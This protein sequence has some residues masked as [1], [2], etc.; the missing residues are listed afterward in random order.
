[1]PRLLRFQPNRWLLTAALLL[2]CGCG[3]QLRSWELD[4]SVSSV[5]IAGAGGS[6]S[7]AT[8]IAG[9]LRSAF[10]QAGVNLA[11]SRS[12]ADLV[13]AL[14]DQRNTR[15]SI[16]VTGQ[17]RAA[18]Y[19]INRSVQYAVSRQNPGET[20]APPKVLIEPRW[21]RVTR[22]FRV[23]RNNIVGSNEEQALVERELKSDIIQQVI[24]SINLVL[25]QN[26]TA[27]GES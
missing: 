21:I 1:M 16:S 18:E 2:L 15:R 11:S 6:A 20:I 3:F 10:K 25:E 13:V 23:D 7:A 5:F 19:E 9:D 24:R 4:S 26:Q 27:V 12:E 8:P 17:A 14:L 22:V